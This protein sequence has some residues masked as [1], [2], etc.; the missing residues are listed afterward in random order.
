MEV[1]GK[2]SVVENVKRT[3]PLHVN[4]IVNKLTHKEYKML[5]ERDISRIIPYNI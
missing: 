4:A 3:F 2:Y 5:W 1:E